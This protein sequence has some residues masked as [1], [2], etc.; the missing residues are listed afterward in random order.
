[1]SCDQVLNA[2]SSH[3]REKMGLMRIRSGMLRY[4]EHST[5]RYFTQVQMHDVVH[6]EIDEVLA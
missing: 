1:M 5:L 4:F 3:Y 6:Q 2:L